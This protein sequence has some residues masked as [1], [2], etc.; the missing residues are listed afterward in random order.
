MDSIQV[1]IGLAVIGVVVS[2]FGF[3]AAVVMGSSP[4]V[5]PRDVKII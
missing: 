4:G 2:I 3:I 5:L 1:G